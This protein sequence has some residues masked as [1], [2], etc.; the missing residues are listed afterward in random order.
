MQT[1]KRT[2]KEEGRGRGRTTQSLF[3]FSSLVVTPTTEKE[4]KKVSQLGGPPVR[5][6]TYL[7]WKEKGK[8]GGRSI[9]GSFLAAE[10]GTKRD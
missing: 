1:E 4:G 5:P 10:K 3:S 6:P 9:R 7:V 2:E 8:G